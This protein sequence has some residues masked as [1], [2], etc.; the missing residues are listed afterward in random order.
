MVT[1]GEVPL[2]LVRKFAGIRGYLG[3]NLP[4]CDFISTPHKYMRLTTENPTYAVTLA[5]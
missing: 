3:D 2:V 1:R 4:G 5:L